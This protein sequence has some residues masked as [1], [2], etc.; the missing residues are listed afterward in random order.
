VVA[1]LRAVCSWKFP[2][3]R[4][5]ESEAPRIF[6]ERGNISTNNEREI[7]MIDTKTIA[8]IVRL[9]S[10][11]R[12]ASQIAS[13]L[14]VDEKTVRKYATLPKR[15]MGNNN[16][17][18]LLE[19]TAAESRGKLAAK[20]FEFFER[21]VRP[22]QVVVRAQEPPEVVLE[23]HK[24]WVELKAAGTVIIQS[25]E[26][27]TIRTQVSALTSRL[28]SLDKAVSRSPLN[29]P[30]NNISCRCGARGQFYLPVHCR[31]CGEI[32]FLPWG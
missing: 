31:I 20:L 24:R 27:M 8:K 4:G 30:N 21:G 32:L 17:H 26:A 2:G 7:P 22:E 5:A 25:R 18:G 3:R 12:T 13:K 14:K 10:R 15:R 28:G 11:G 6:R 23:L 1:A 9:S 16:A 29:H 19:K